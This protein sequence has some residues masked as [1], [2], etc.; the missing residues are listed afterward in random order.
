M[1]DAELAFYGDTK[2]TC[3]NVAYTRSPVSPEVGAETR[4]NVT[5]KNKATT[6]GYRLTS[7]K[8]QFTAV[9]SKFAWGNPTEAPDKP[10]YVRT[11]ASP[12]TSKYSASNSTLRWRT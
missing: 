12:R 3:R 4:K 1:Y 9:W 7:S 6:S 5:R 2:N 11:W 10:P 8:A